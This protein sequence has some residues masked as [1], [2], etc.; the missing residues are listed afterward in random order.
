MEQI[1][2][3]LPLGN[4]VPLLQ[5][6]VARRRGTCFFLQKPLDYRDE[7]ACNPKPWC[8]FYRPSVSLG[9]VLLTIRSILGGHN[10]ARV[11]PMAH[12]D[13]RI[14]CQVAYCLTLGGVK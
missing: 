8:H 12:N 10:A 4:K 11:I 5:R 13:D 7:I 9:S 14:I 1:R 6:V 3:L 2:Y